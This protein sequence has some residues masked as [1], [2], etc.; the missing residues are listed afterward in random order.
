MWAETGL[1]YVNNGSYK[2]F[3]Q[4]NPQARKDS[5]LLSLY[6]EN[7]GI[8]IVFGQ[9]A[10]G[11]PAGVTQ[12]EINRIVQSCI[13]SRRVVPLLNASR[14]TINNGFADRIFCHDSASGVVSS[15]T[16]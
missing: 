5:L 10:Y 4:G 1:F 6:S 11:N 8:E 7:G 9:K 16:N 14:E 15:R 3:Q 2:G 13:E 12:P